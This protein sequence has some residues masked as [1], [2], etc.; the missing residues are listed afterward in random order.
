MAQDFRH[1]DASARSSGPVRVPCVGAV[2]RDEAGRLLMILRGHNPGKG[3]W[4]IPGGRIEPG[5]TPEQAVIR[6]VREETGLRVTCGPL[7][8]VAELA[9]LDGAIVDIRD[10][11]A[12]LEPGSATVPEAGDDAADVRWVTDS[13]AATMDERG[14]ITAGLLTTLLT[15]MRTTGSVR[16]QPD[17]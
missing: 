3:L 15:W 14:E 11:R 4:S 1:A 6:E 8:G 2:V 9:G 5:E 16:T 13:E 7:L 10:Y 17:G 12:F